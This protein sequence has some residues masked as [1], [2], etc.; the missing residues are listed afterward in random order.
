MTNQYPPSEWPT[1]RMPGDQWPGAT[2]GP[3]Y[4]GAPADAYPAPRAA[5]SSLPIVLA[6]LLVG[7]LAVVG[8]ALGVVLIGKNDKATT[9]APS[10]AAPVSPDVVTT[11]TTTTVTAQTPAPAPGGSAPF[12]GTD[13]QGFL[14]GTAR[15]NVDDPA[16]FIGRTNRSEV[17]VCRAAS[18]SGGL[19]Y[20]GYADG[21]ASPDVSWPR[22]IG[23]TYVFTSGNTTYEV[24]PSALT[25]RTPGGDVTEAWID[26]WRR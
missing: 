5:R 16:V 3:V 20:K 7:A 2:T 12:T 13:G 18:S 6:V 14:S 10:V 21:S 24:G 19:Y 9:P 15:C 8:V 25:I 4:Q 17:V 1:E 11:T 26:V 23:S 22:M